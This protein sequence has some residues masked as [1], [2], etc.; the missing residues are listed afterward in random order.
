MVYENVLSVA[1]I[2]ALGIKR[3]RSSNPEDV[4][5]DSINFFQQTPKDKSVGDLLANWK[6]KAFITEFKATEDQVMDEIRKF[7]KESLITNLNNDKVIQQYSLRGHFIGYGEYD[8]QNTEILADL[9]FK[10]YLSLL[11]SF[12]VTGEGFN[13]FTDRLTNDPEL[14]LKGDEMGKYLEFLKKHA[15]NIADGKSGTGSGKSITPIE[16]VVTVVS[17]D[18]TVMSLRYRSYQHLFRLMNEKISLELLLQQQIKY[19]HALVQGQS[20][21][22]QQGKDKKRGEGKGFK[23]GM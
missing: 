16:G 6:G 7:G 23:F 22:I 17:A 10:P 18:S 11:E 9:R 4:I 12:L 14:G 3:G 5:I 8:K 1:F 13:S 15:E 2:Y 20:Q 19:R 21:K